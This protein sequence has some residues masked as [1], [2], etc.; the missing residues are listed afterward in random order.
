MVTC[1]ITLIYTAE[2]GLRAVVLTD[3][4]Q[5][6]IMLGGAALVIV[7]VSVDG[8]WWCVR[9]VAAAVGTALG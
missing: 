9:V 1:I 5:S 8:L 7:L 4:I 3:A 6:L 2:G